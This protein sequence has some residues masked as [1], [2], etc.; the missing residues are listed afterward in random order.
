[1]FPQCSGW[2]HQEQ[3]HTHR[4]WHSTWPAYTTECFQWEQAISKARSTLWAQKRR[5]LTHGK[6][7]VQKEQCNLLRPADSVQAGGHVHTQILIP[8]FPLQ[9]QT[10]P[11]RWDAGTLTMH[12]RAQRAMGTKC[13]PRET[14]DVSLCATIKNPQALFTSL[15]EKPDGREGCKIWNKNL[16]L[17]QGAVGR[18]GHQPGNTSLYWSL[19][20]AY[21]W[22]PPCLQET[23]KL[24]PENKQDLSSPG[25]CEQLLGLMKISTSLISSQNVFLGSSSPQ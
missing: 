5:Q 8:L 4:R 1:M 13:F 2:G 21:A 6:C 25:G 12:S 16:I 17:P 20:Q 15:D 23:S 14:G 24:H 3:C 7:S 11:A 19:S 22:L 9:P 10:C 18:L